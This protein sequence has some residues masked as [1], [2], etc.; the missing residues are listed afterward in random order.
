MKK[1]VNKVLSRFG[2]V[3]QRIPKKEMQGKLENGRNLLNEL[4]G[5]HLTKISG[6]PADKLE[7]PLPWFTYPSIEFIDQFDLSE[8]TVFEWGSGNSSSFFAARANSI[9]SVEHEKDWFEHVKK[10]IKDNQELV[11]SA[12]QDYPFVLKNINKKFDIIIIDGRRRLDCTKEAVVFLKE[13][14]LIIL[15][16][17]DRYDITSSYLRQQGFVQV[18]FHGFGPINQYTWTT[19]IFFKNKINLPLHNNLQP[20]QPIGGLNEDEGKIIIDEDTKY[21]TS[22][23]QFIKSII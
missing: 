5:H 21:G 4:Y 15:D 16:N 6:I 13:D 14:G 9:I 7:N 23:A 12:L 17:S 11:F 1:I 8:K 2:V 10:N 3:L 22:N 18:D 20:K 19:S